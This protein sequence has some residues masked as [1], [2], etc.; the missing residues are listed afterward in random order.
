MVTGETQSFRSLALLAC[1]LVGP[2]L[3]LIVFIL[4]GALR[5]GYDSMKLPVSSLSIGPSGWIQQVNFIVTGVLVLGYAVGLKGS[6]DGYAGSTWGPRLVGLVGAGLV[7]AGVFTTDPVFGYPTTHP[8][9]LSQV[10]LHGHLHDLSSACVFVLLPGA[11]IVFARLFRRKG[12]I[13]WATYSLLTAACMPVLLV[14]SASGFRQVPGLVS[15]AGL[16]Q[17]LTIGAGWLWMSLMA[18]H[19]MR[20][21]HGA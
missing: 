6:F 11:C 8:L 10:T 18:L 14:L 19:L 7:G 4:E 20:R 15:V 9:L 5:P 1:G 17:R 3:F 21:P 12:E 13:R 2:P 16:F